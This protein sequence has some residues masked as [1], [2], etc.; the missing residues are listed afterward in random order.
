VYD[1]GN[2]ILESW[3]MESEFLNLKK[4]IA[5]APSRNFVSGA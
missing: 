5:T 2:F 4:Y 3:V 1:T